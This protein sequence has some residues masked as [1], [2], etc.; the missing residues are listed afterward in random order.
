MKFNASTIT[1]GDEFRNNKL[2]SLKPLF[3]PNIRTQILFQRTINLYNDRKNNS[4]KFDP[5]D[6]SII[7][8]NYKKYKN[9]NKSCLMSKKNL[10]HFNQSMIINPKSYKN[11]NKIYRINSENDINIM[12]NNISKN[13]NEI[14]NI[15]RFSIISGNIG[16]SLRRF[17]VITDLKI[18]SK[19]LL[20]LKRFR[21]SN[22]KYWLSDSKNNND[23]NS[24]TNDRKDRSKN[25][26]K[27]KF[28]VLNKNEKK[29]LKVQYYKWFI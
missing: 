14:K 7:I 15:K 27:N 26:E 2:K 16:L 29:D 5:F 22:T 12:D 20:S 4:K 3:M 13:N 11:K 1:T 17:S 21:L 23:Y 28:K 24:S 25:N 6:G 18:K 8:K 10:N 19:N 9:L